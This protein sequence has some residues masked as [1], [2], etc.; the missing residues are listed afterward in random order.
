MARPRAA[1][2]PAAA[3]SPAADRHPDLT[4]GGSVG[5]PTATAGREPGPTAAAQVAA[6]HDGSPGSSTRGARRLGPRPDPSTTAATPAAAVDGDTPSVSRRVGGIPAPTA[7]APRAAAHD[8][9]HSAA[10]PAGCLPGP[11]PTAAA[12]VANDGEALCLSRR[13][14]PFSDPTAAAHGAAEYDGGRPTTRPAGRRPGPT[15][16]SA[17]GG[18]TVGAAPT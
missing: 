5:K 2:P 12:A 10:R 6:T 3:G 13:A 1:P 7:A 18:T 9:G 4:V 17:T 14:G 16:V 8:G 11:T 15:A